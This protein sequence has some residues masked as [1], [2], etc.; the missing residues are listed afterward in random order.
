MRTANTEYGLLSDNELFALSRK[1]D[2]EAYEVLYFR[3]WPRLV[4]TAYRRLVSKQRA[5]DIIQDLLIN[6]FRR[7]HEIELTGSLQSYL[8]QALKYRILNEYR[9]NSVHA[10][11]HRDLFFNQLC[12]NDFA[13]Q[14]EEKELSNCIET[15]LSRL[16]EKCKEAFLLS[17]KDHLSNKEISERMQ[18]S[19]ST[20]EKHIG[21][22]IKF[23]RETMKV[24]QVI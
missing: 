1:D 12:K 19:V 2:N 23:L 24:Y 11:V 6:V 14:L 5:E 13:H 16:P 3:H 10:G 21:K 17:R 15:A 22:A 8:N 7:R 18:I 20:V 9:A 4:D